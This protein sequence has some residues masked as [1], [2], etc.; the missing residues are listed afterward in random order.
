[1]KLNHECIRDL[2]LEIESFP[3]DSFPV[4]GPNLQNILEKYTPDDLIYSVQQLIDAKYIDGICD[5][6]LAGRYTIIINTITWKGNKFLDNIRDPE[7]WSETTKNTAKSI[8]SAS[9]SILSSVAAKLIESKL[10][11]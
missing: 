9:L 5:S 8:K 7:I 10:G 11:L 3:L 4:Q 6:D 1:M 2:L